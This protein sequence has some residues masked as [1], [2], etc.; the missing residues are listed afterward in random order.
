MMATTRWRRSA[1]E[2][3]TGDGNCGAYRDL[4]QLSY[5]E[6]GGGNDENRSRWYAPNENGPETIHQ[7]CAGLFQEL[8]ALTMLNKAED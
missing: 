3:R 1:D 5:D 8:Q 4:S 7:G 6:S 2:P